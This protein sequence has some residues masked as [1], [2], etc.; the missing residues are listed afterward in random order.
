MGRLVIVTETHPVLGRPLSD[1]EVTRIQAKA[2]A[3]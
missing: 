2:K 1:A 3:A